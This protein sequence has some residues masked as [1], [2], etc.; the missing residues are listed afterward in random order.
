MVL[1]LVLQNF[2]D[3]LWL[4][5]V[6][7]HRGFIFQDIG[8]HSDAGKLVHNYIFCMGQLQYYYMCGC[9][10]GLTPRDPRRPAVYVASNR[11]LLLRINCQTDQIICAYQLHT[12]AIRTLS[13]HSGFAKLS[14]PSCLII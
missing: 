3:I 1:F 7:V 13:I 10:K 14:V 8:F 12:C 5:M 11:G 6:H 9:N 4:N 2:H